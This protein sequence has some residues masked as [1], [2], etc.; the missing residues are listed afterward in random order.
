MT[1]TPSPLSPSSAGI[2]GEGTVATNSL[3]IKL[4]TLKLQDFCTSIAS[5]AHKVSS[6][7]KILLSFSSIN[8]WRHLY[9][10]PHLPCSHSSKVG[11]PYILF[12]GPTNAQTPSTVSIQHSFAIFGTRCIPP[13]PSTCVLHCRSFRALYN[14]RNSQIC[15]DEKVVSCRLK[16]LSWCRIHPR[17][18]T[19][20]LKCARTLSKQ[21]STCADPNGVLFLP[22]K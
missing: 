13:S 20:K 10:R 16:C 1:P 5:K 19:V 8:P 9:S 4:L 3:T 7:W 14:C 2:D 11:A 6:R 15:S 18:A 21:R 22:K 17:T 12:H